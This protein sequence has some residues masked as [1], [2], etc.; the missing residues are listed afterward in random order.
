MPAGKMMNIL[1]KTMGL[2]LLAVSCVSSDAQVTAGGGKD[3]GGMAVLKLQF[4][5]RIVKKL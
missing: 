4:F 5:V 3:V 1:I 2:C